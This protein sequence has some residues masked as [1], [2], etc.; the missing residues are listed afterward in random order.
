MLASDVADLHRALATKWHGA[1]VPQW[2]SDNG[3]WSMLAETWKRCYA[4]L[5]HHAQGLAVSYE[6][7]AEALRWAY[8]SPRTWGDGATWGRVLSGRQGAR[9][10]CDKALVI[11]D[12]MDAD[13]GRTGWPGANPAYG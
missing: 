13:Q 1:K 3:E 8:Q 5:H 6:K 4:G 10:L 2:L 12:Q 11:L 9:V 7:Q